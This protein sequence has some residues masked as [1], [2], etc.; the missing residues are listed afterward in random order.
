MVCARA[1]SATGAVTGFGREKP[2]DPPVERDP[3]EGGVNRYLYLSFKRQE[4]GLSNSHKP[5]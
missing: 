3:P 1:L 4:L 2:E 5:P